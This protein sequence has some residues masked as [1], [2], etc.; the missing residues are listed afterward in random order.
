VAAWVVLSQRSQ[1][2]TE[3]FRLV[4]HDLGAVDGVSWGHLRGFVRGL[5][6]M[7]TEL[8][9]C[10][11]HT[12]PLLSALPEF[13]ERVE[14]VEPFLLRIADVRAALWGRG[15]SPV[16]RG[17]V[18]FAVDDPLLTAN[19]GPW[20]LTVD[21]GRAEVLPC[22]RAEVTLT[23]GGLAS[24]YTGHATAHELASLGQASGPA[25]ELERLGALFAG[26]TPGLS[27]FF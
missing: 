19:Q 27:E 11:G 13:R 24:L 10:F 18:S 21:A 26:P 6:A 12:S 20:T 14:L 15:W 8:E 7:N 4:L 3:F 23:I 17:E 22:A 9:L 25:E 1:P 5:A 2:G 16:L